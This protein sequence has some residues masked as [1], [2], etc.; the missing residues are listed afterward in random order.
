MM[1]Q[2]RFCVECSQRL[3][4]YN[5]D[6]ICHSC[7]VNPKEVNKILREIRGMANGK[8]KPDKP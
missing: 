5:D 6:V 3:S 2:D 4:A 1:S 8:S 7:V